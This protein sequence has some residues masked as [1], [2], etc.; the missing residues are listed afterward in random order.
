MNQVIGNLDT[1]ERSVEPVAAERVATDHLDP[2]DVL[3]HQLED[4]ARALGVPRKRSHVVS[5]GEQPWQQQGAD[6]AARAGDEDG[7]PRR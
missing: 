7:H 4:V 1:A 2:G 3:V 5:L 6:E